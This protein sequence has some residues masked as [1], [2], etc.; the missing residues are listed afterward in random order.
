MF[1]KQFALLGASLLGALFEASTAK[2]PTSAQVE[3][4]ATSVKSTAYTPR[5]VAAEQPAP[6]KPAAQRTVVLQSPLIFSSI[7]RHII[8]R[9][10]R[11]RVKYGR[12]RWIILG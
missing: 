1:K 3:E 2:A 12:N 6:A 10:M 9:P 7:S 11:R 5:T 8:E 4:G